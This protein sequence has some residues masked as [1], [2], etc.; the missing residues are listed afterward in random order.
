M[1]HPV[2]P[3]S[4]SRFFTAQAV[5][6]DE[7]RATQ[8]LHNNFGMF[9]TASQPNNP[10]DGLVSRDDLF[11]VYKNPN[12][13]QEQRDAAAYFLTHSEAFNRLDVAQN[14]GLPDGLIGQGDVDTVLYNQAAQVLNSNFGVFDTASQPNRPADGLVSREDLLAVYNNPNATQEQRDAAVYLLTH[15][16]AFNRLDTAQ[17]GGSPDG[18]IGQ[19]DVAT[20]LYPPFTQKAQAIPMDENQ[21]TQVLS[22]NFAVFDTASQPISPADGLVSRDDLLAVYNNPNA[23]QEQRDAA[24]YLLTHEDAFNHL[25][26]A[27]N[28]GSTDGLIGLGD[29][30][31]ALYFPGQ[32]QAQLASMDEGRA[33][34]VLNENFWVFDTASQPNRSA[35][36]L[37]SRDDLLAV[38]NNPNATQEQR[39]AAAYFLTHNEAFNRLDTAQNGGSPDGLIGQGDVA[40]ATYSSAQQ[41]AQSITS[42]S[43]SGATGSSASGATNS[44]KSSA[45]SGSTSGA[46]SSSASGATSAN[47]IKS[48]SLSDGNMGWL[49][50][51]AIALG[52]AAGDLADKMKELAEKISADNGAPVNSSAG[53]TAS[54]S[55]EP[56]PSQ[57]T[58]DNTRLQGLSQEYSTLM[59]TIS[60][61]LKTI[62]EAQSSMARK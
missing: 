1:Y 21:A 35:D 45:A 6:M 52:K 7:N 16:E 58:Q 62:G 4:P 49:E 37:V 10:A 43:P 33:T 9:D 47:T 59:N 32:Q 20:V 2:L 56:D 24:A 15:E 50:A 27:Q 40:T 48:A 57:A 36:G 5:P 51:I 46:T 17:N 42:G 28:G 8:V 3:V 14:G 29:V 61:I 19:G 25:D 11:A 23:T 18:L 22:N 53:S 44:S 31:T 26:T 41:M 60:T 13:T 55:S 39:A 54:A 12:A 38:Y 30:A 34:Q